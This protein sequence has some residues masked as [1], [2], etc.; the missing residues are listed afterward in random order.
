MVYIIMV[1]PNLKNLLYL[2]NIT[3]IFWIY[4]FKILLIPEWWMWHLQLANWWLVLC[5]NSRWNC[6]TDLTARSVPWRSGTGLGCWKKVKAPI[7]RSSARMKLRLTPPGSPSS[8]VLVKLLSYNL[9]FLKKLANE[10][11]RY[12]IYFGESL[13]NLHLYNKQTL[14]CDN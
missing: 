11:S 8:L 7:L 12:I 2:T 3:R 9:L 13:K 14:I 10:S 5:T 1:M 6:P 4:N